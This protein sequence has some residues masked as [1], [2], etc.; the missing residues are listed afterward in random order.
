M[1]SG[2]VTL[3]GKSQNLIRETPAE[4]PASA[5][6]VV[7]HGR[8]SLVAFEC[9]ALAI[10]FSRPLFCAIDVCKILPRLELAQDLFVVTDQQQRGT[11]L[12][13]DFADQRQ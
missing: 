12:A 6:R 3:S 2:S 1:I 8:H 7:P 9:S 10:S 13:A 11:L 5:A 4:C